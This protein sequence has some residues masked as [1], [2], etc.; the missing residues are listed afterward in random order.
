M[1]RILVVSTVVTLSLSSAAGSRAQDNGQSPGEPIQLATLQRQAVEADPR[2]RE[3]GLVEEQTRLRVRNIT[4]ENLPTLTAFGQSHDQSDVP[5]APFTLPGGQVLFS[6]PKGTYDLSV[7]VDQHLFDPTH[8]PRLAL[9]EADLA[10]SQARLRTTLFAVRDEVNDAF[11]MAALLE[12]QIGALAATLD[13]LT[14]RSREIAARVRE[15]TALAADR[16]VIEAAILQYQQQD[17]ELRANRA[18]ALARLSSLTGH[19]IG[20]DAQLALPELAEAVGRARGALD[21]LRMRPEYEQFARTRDQVAR[22][23]D[24]AAASERPQLSAFGRAGYGKPGL[25]FINDRAESYALG[26][27]QLQWKGWTWGLA[28]RERQALG[29][30]QAVVSAE[31]AAFTETLHRAAETGL[32]TIDRLAASLTLDDRIIALRQNVDG[33]TR[34]RLGEGAVTAARYI[35]RH[36]ELLAAQFARSGHRVELAH[37]RAALLTM[38]GLEVQ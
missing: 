26:G 6:P 21:Q 16:D 31:E 19:S 2:A 20:P 10:A 34:V 33:V 35:D 5:R 32:S 1:N 28:G 36:T 30:Q 4:V 3:V 27:V 15:G 9:A 22:Q 37:A 13:D 14:A 38:L 7:R 24:M 23:Q 17:A 11:F 8:Q 25:N 29:M 12:Q 18:A